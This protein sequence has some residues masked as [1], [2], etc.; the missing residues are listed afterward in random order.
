MIKKNIEEKKRRKS[1]ERNQVC[2]RVLW[3][4]NLE[5]CANQQW[6]KKRML[7]IPVDRNKPSSSL[8]SKHN[9][10]RLMI[11]ILPRMPLLLLVVLLLMLLLPFV[12]CRHWLFLYYTDKAATKCTI[13]LNLLFLRLFT[14][15][16]IENNR[17]INTHTHTSGGT[18]YNDTAHKSQKKAI[19]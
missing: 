7:S 12:V 16:S 2:F 11:I 15:D 17:N 13:K 19:F 1:M 9:V 5:S 18:A 14:S 3:E 8:E 6:K 10:T 4:R